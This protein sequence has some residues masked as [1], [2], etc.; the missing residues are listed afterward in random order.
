M[1]DK[2]TIESVLYDQQ[3]ELQ[4]KKLLKFCHR[5][6]ESLIDMDSPQAQVVI[7]VR[8]S[9]KSTLCYNA[10][11]SSGAK[12]AYINFDDERLAKITGD[13][14]NDMLEVLYKIYGDFTHLFIDEIQNI[15]E[16]YL[17]VNRL[18]R[19]NMR[20]I[21]TGSNAKLLSGE[22]ATHLTGKNNKI[23]LYPFSFSEY[24]AF[25]DIDTSSH[26]TKAEAFRRAAFDSYISEGGFPEMLTIKNKL[27][28]VSELVDNILKRDI[29]RRHKIQ[30]TAAFE[31]MAQH[32][33]NVS[34]TIL[35]DQSIQETFSLKSVHTVKNYINYL[36]Q[37]YLLVSLQKYSTKSRLRVVGEK[38]YPVDVALMNYRLNALAGKNLGWRM[39]TIVYLELLRRHRPEGRDVYYFA[40]RSGECDFL[41]CQGN[42]AVM[43]IQ[44]SY[45]LS[46]PKT[47][48]RELSGLI[49]ASRKTK[50][51]NLLLLTDHEREDIRISGHDIIVRPVYEWALSS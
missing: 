5:R 15:D 26:T 51:S 27:G 16:W 21:I 24:C 38:I 32:L 45:D 28:Y 20:V 23:E 14:L 36:R 34:P 44:V 41:I 12:Y 48:K 47:K 3:D 31:Q 22:L 29:E 42:A 19:R 6:E 7:G 17:F 4:N 13:D 25:K 43:A 11:E 30:H 9:G 18:L 2:R 39:E 40:D 49:L 37:A 46:D 35:S 33:L 50:C 10:L 8:R 1:P